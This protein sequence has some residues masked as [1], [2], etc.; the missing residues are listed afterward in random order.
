MTTDTLTVRFPSAGG[1]DDDRRSD[2]FRHLLATVSHLLH[3]N[4]AHARADHRTVHTR[5]VLSVLL[6]GYVQFHA[7][8]DRVLL[9]ELQVSRQLHKG[10]GTFGTK[11]DGNLKIF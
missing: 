11:C 1:K 2:D 5:R 6:A 8:P 9:D 10:P 7:Q 3:R 4:V